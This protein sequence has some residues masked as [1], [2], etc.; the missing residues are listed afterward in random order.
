[1]SLTPHVAF[2]FSGGRPRSPV[3]PA[4]RTLSPLPRSSPVPRRLPSGG[5]IP[6]WP[7]PFF[8]T[9]LRRRA[10]SA[11][12]HRPPSRDPSPPHWLTVATSGLGPTVFAFA[13]STLRTLRDSA[14]RSVGEPALS[15]PR[16]HRSPPDFLVVETRKGT[17]LPEEAGDMGLGPASIRISGSFRGAGNASSSRPFSGLS[18]GFILGT[19]EVLKPLSMPPFCQRSMSLAR[20]PQAKRKSRPASTWNL[21]KR[22]MTNKL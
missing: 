11:T 9:R 4:F 12:Y 1:M 16:P 17:T 6:R 19:F 3:P 13:S 5:L 7:D 20:H 18:P 22:L 14:S 10:D 15:G 21:H 8:S 2:L